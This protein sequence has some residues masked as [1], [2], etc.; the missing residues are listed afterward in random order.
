MTLDK[1][2]LIELIEK[3]EVARL[4]ALTQEQ[5][6]QEYCEWFSCEEYEIGEASMLNDL[7]EDYMR[8]RNDDS[9]EELQD[10][11]ER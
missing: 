9:V 11:L 1:D 3:K 7:M 8:Y 10:I 5:L 4:N 2:E 6:T